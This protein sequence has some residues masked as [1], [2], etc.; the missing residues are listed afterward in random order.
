MQGCFFVRFLLILM[1]L[2]PNQRNCLRLTAKTITRMHFHTVHQLCGK[3][4]SNS[5]PGHS[6]TDGAA[7]SAP[8]QLDEGDCEMSG[9]ADW[10][11]KNIKKLTIILTNSQSNICLWIGETAQD[12]KDFLGLWKRHLLLLEGTKPGGL[13]LQAIVIHPIDV[14]VCKWC[15]MFITS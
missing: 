7:G 2:V 15:C 6:Q 13:N 9:Q 5:V 11:R 12:C 10:T 8:Q 3:E 4:W 14:G 1:L